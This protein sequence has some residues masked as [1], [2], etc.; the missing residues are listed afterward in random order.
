MLKDTTVSSELEADNEAD[1][2]ADDENEGLEAAPGTCR[3]AET[4]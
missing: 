2:E 3:L 4:V 1:D